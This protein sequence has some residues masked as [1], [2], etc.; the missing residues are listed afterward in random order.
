[1]TTHPAQ[2]VFTEVRQGKWRGRLLRPSAV[3]D[4]ESGKPVTWTP[5]FDIEQRR[6][7]TCHVTMQGGPDKGGRR[8]ASHP[9]VTTAQKAGIRWAG[10]RFR[11]EGPDP[12]DC[13]CYYG[14]GDDSL[15]E[16]WHQ[17]EDDPC[18]V[19]PNAPMVG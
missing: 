15:S 9:D 8:Y 3:I 19:H 12:S 6:D 10:R 7:G 16:T 5:R 11:V 17:H 2:I 4:R 18:P 13:T 1:M 14:C